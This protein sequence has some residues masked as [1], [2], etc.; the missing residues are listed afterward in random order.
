MEYLISTV[1]K[2]LNTKVKNV[3]PIGNGS[4]ASCY[5]VEISN[6]P[7]K[8]VV[9]TS[10]HYELMLEEMKMNNFIRERVHFKI[11]ETYLMASEWNE[12]LD[13]IPS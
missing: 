6:Y 13:L 3:Y 10:S 4:T 1:E 12:T 9:K 5:A 2:E 11:P 8:L 7:F